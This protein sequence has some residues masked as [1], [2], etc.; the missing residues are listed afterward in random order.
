M[1]TAWNDHSLSAAYQTA[2]GTPNET[3]N[4]F[5]A[6]LCDRPEV[7]FEHEVVE[8]DLMSGQVGAA[9][10]RLVGRRSGTLRFSYPLEGFVSDYDTVTGAGD[11]PGAA[12]VNAA[13]EIIPPWF[14]L[15]ANAM[16][17]N[18]SAVATSANFWRGVGATSSVYTSGG[19]GSGTAGTILCDDEP[20]AELYDVGELVVAAL[21]ATNTAPQIGYIQEKDTVTLTLFENAVNNVNSADAHLYGTAN[22]YASSEITSTKAV[23]FR[24]T[25]PATTDC[26]VLEDAYADSV[27][28]T[29]D[30]GAIP[31]AEFS[32][33]F[34]NYQYNT[35]DGELVVPIGYDRIPQIVGSNNARATIDGANKCGL[36]GCTWEWKPSAIRETKCHGSSNGVSAVEI[37]APRITA[38]FTIVHDSGDDNLDSAGVATTLGQHEWFSRFELGSAITV[39]VYVGSRV[40]KIFAFL[41]PNG[42]IVATPDVQLRDDATVAYGLVVEAGAYTGDETDGDELVSDSPYNSL[43]R[44]SLA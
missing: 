31:T 41:I 25:G 9:P 29:W 33:K 6:L 15:L 10:E 26:Y 35:L 39:G 8:L 18:M 12:P 5:V 28:L 14:V 38:G 16:G 2:H 4:E 44:V 43:A 11:N 24:W 3:D 30:S 17:S 21:S 34:Y 22:A 40:G 27:K 1:G 37:L 20:T 32:Y 36:E 7:K 13:N 23:T 19:M 42:I